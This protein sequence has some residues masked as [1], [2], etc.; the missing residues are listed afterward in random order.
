M[1]FDILQAIFQ[2]LRDGLWIAGYRTR[3]SRARRKIRLTEGQ[4]IYIMTDDGNHKIGYFARE[5]GFK[6]WEWT[7]E[8]R[9]A[10]IDAVKVESTRLEWVEE[11]YEEMQQ[12]AA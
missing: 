1:I 7:R 11:F 2:F 10:V 12:K 8:S 6:T 5:D 4:G 9:D 3:R